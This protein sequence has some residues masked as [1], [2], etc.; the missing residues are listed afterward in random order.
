MG[1]DTELDELRALA[2]S[3]KDYL[4]QLQMREQRNTGISSLK[5]A[6]NRVVGYYLEVTN[7]HKDKVPNEWIRKQTMVGG[8]RY[9]C[10]LRSLTPSSHPD[11]AEVV[12]EGDRPSERSGCAPTGREDRMPADR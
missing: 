4:L 5:V 7:A 2:F 12:E 9:V 10:P 6:Y 8:E 11:P 1:I 3:G